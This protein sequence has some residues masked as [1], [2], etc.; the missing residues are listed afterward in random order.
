MSIKWFTNG[1]NNQTCNVFFGTFQIIHVPIYN[2]FRFSKCDNGWFIWENEYNQITG[3]MFTSIDEAK[4]E[5]ELIY[6]NLLK[7]INTGE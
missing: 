5:F 1:L 7:L 3:R 4:K 6:S 2:R